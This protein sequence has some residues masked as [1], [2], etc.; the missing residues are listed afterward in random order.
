MYLSAKKHI[1]GWK[2]GDEEVKYRTITEI[3]GL[4]GMVCEDIPSLTVSVN[5]VYWRKANAIH[6][7]FVDNVQDGKDDCGE[8]DVSREQLGDLVAVC[9]K[10]LA[11]FSVGAAAK[12]L[13][14][15]G[16]F[17]FGST[18]YDEDYLQDVRLTV[19][20]VKPFLTL[21][22]FDFEYHSSW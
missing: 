16:G 10:V 18:A 21:E 20:R 8:Y 22:G 19:E 3:I 17:F 7:W 9:E 14:T 12:T 1:S 11:D 13:P 2:Y 4:G 15:Q 5:V 6:K